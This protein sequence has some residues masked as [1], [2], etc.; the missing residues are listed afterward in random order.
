MSPL[1]SYQLFKFIIMG[2]LAALVHFSV[3]YLAV[4]WFNLAPVWGNVV[5]FMVAFLVSFLGHLT[6]T[7]KSQTPQSQ[8]IVMARLLK[9]LFS[10]LAGFILNQALF[11]LGL[12]W[13]GDAYYLWIWLVVTAIVTVLSFLLGKLWAFK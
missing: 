1:A 12:S 6:V 8:S 9:W 4:S 11:M 13:I 7:F 10:S 2:S 5:A 3:L